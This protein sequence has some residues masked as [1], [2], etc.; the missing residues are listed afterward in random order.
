MIRDKI[1]G[2]TE[3]KRIIAARKKNKEKIVFTNGCFDLLHL[4]HVRYL[5]QA[6]K[7]GNRLIVAVNSDSSVRKLKGR[8]RPI[9]KARER[10]SLVAA[11][12]VFAMPFSAVRNARPVWSSAF[13]F[14]VVSC[15][16]IVGL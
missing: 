16:A 10:A 3:L 4:G 9:M 2:L 8:R 5:E 14:I 7:L 13:S 11:L 15:F 1:K 6:A 12:S